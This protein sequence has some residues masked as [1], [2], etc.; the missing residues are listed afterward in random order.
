MALWGYSPQLRTVLLRLANFAST[1]VFA[2]KVPFYHKATCLLWG[3]TAPSHCPAEHIPGDSRY[4]CL[5][6]QLVTP[7]GVLV[8]QEKRSVSLAGQ[9]LH[10]ATT[11][12]RAVIQ[13]HQVSTGWHIAASMCS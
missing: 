3:N 2:N 7:F 5:C 10:R 6:W 8:G 4:G 12:C 13:Q 9:Q 11:L 1:G